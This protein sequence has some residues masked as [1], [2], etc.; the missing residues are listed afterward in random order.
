M[1]KLTKALLIYLIPVLFFAAIF[2]LIISNEEPEKYS[3]NTYYFLITV[4]AFII[5]LSPLIILVIIT[6]RNKNKVLLGIINSI[7]IWLFIALFP[8]A[9]IGYLRNAPAAYLFGGIQFI[10]GCFLIQYY[11]FPR[12]FIFLGLFLSI[13]ANLY[14]LI[15]GA[16]RRARHQQLNLG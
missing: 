5:L 2:L 8:S 13:F 14:F 1:N 3:F 16:I 6:Y 10:M 9:I 4:F 11:K 15:Y 12:S 7:I